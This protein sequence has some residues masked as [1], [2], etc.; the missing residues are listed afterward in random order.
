MR[1]PIILLNRSR[2]R[3]PNLCASDR[4]LAGVCALFMRPARVIRSAIVL[5]PSTILEFHRA[6]R[7]RKYRWL[8]S[9]TR[10]RTGPQGPSKALVDAIVDMKRRNPRWG[11]PRI[12]QQI[13]LAFAVDIDKDVV[14]R[15]LATHYRLA[16]HSGGPSWLTFLGHAK[17]SLWSIDLFRCESAILRSH[18]VLV[19]MDHYTRRIVGFG[20][21]AGTVDGRALCRMFNHAIRGLSRPTRLQLRPR[22]AVSVSPMA[23]QPAGAAGD[24][25]EE[26]AVCAAVA[27]VCRTVD[28]HAA[29]RMRGS[30]AVLV[31]VGLGRQTGGLPGL[32]QCASGPCVV[33]RADARPDTKGCRT[34]RPLPMGRAL[35][36]S[37][38][39][40]DRGVTS[41][42]RRRWRAGRRARVRRL[43]RHSRAVRQLHALLMPSRQR[44]GGLPA[45]GTRRSNDVGFLRIRHPQA[46]PLDAEC[47]DDR[48]ECRSAVL[49]P[50]VGRAFCRRERLS[51]ADASVAAPF[52][53]RGS[54]ESVADDAS[55]RDVSGQ[56]TRWIA[57]AR[58]LHGAW[59][60]STRELRRLND[61]P[62]SSM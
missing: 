51:A 12:A 41:D 23:R 13:A 10:R 33:G 39:D 44:R 32:L 40:A 5:R 16:L 45:H 7:T 56:R 54:V 15:V 38:S 14:R 24:R 59:A 31:G 18:W 17:D 26:C 50:V 34:A 46:D 9:P 8:F 55:G 61:G 57:T 2:H 42:Q 47:D 21:H 28:R 53:G 22:P 6:L 30:A 25:G 43:S 1:D 62:N 37:L 11:C 60:L 4:I 49:E 29:T 36:W 19:V 48:V 52:P 27:S 20:I 35:P 3:A 58:F